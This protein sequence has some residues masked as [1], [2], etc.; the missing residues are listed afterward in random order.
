MVRDGSPMGDEPEILQSG[1]FKIRLSRG[2]EEGQRMVPV[3]QGWAEAQPSGG[4]GPCFP[5]RGLSGQIRIR[6]DDPKVRPVAG[7]RGGSV[8][9]GEAF[10][11]F[12][13]GRS[14]HSLRAPEEPDDLM[15]QS[16]AR[17]RGQA[18]GLVVIEVVGRELSNE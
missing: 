6:A 7:G 11:G 1:D 4:L 9:L 5:K 10:Q 12:G 16:S 17:S 8:F 3:G 18:R 15:E 13:S 14:D 2:G